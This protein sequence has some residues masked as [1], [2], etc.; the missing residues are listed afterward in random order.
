[1]SKRDE[2]V[3]KIADIFYEAIKNGT[4]PWVR[5]WKANDFKQLSH[6]PVSQNAYKGLNSLLLDT[7][8]L[9]KGYQSNGWLTFNQAKELDGNIKK[10]EKATTVSFFTMLEVKDKD[11]KDS[12]EKEYRPVVKYFSVFNIDQTENINQDKLKALYEKNSFERDD[13]ITLDDCQKVLDNVNDVKIVHENQKRAF[14]S[15]SRDTIVLPLKEQFHTLEAYYSTAFHELGHSTGHSSRL[16]RKLGNGFG[17]DDYAREELRAEIYSFLQ[18]KELGMDFNLVNHQSYIEGWTRQFADKK[19]EIVEAVKDSL[20]IVDYVNEN[21]I[22]KVLDTDTNKGSKMNETIKDDLSNCLE[23]IN[24]NNKQYAT[25]EGLAIEVI[26]EY[27][28]AYGKVEPNEL[29]SELN[30]LVG[31]DFTAQDIK[32]VSNIAYKEMDMDITLDNDKEYSLKEYKELETKELQ[33]LNKFSEKYNLNVDEKIT[34][35][36]LVGDTKADN[37]AMNEIREAVN[38]VKD[39]T[40]SEQTNTQVNTNTRRNK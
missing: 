16:N 33:K 14:Y 23:A 13:L 18:A 21:Y 28:T 5:E 11:K 34:L 1:M 20:K 32:L 6:N 3:E 9:E 29:K 10:G 17:S 39:E 27:Y 8:K 22:N 40:K 12:D 35:K 26:R 24:N 30:S 19:T 37:T 7:I 38:K 36:D 31:V 2:Q 25:K 15:S 4:A